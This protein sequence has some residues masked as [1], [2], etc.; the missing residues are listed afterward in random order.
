MQTDDIVKYCNLMEEVKRRMNVINAFGSGA[1]HA[2]YKATTVESV[3]LQLRK[4]LEL[5]A[6]GSLVANKQL[7]SQVY[8]DFSKLWNAKKL[9]ADIEH[10]HRIVVALSETIRL[11]TAIDCEIEKHGGWPGAFQTAKKD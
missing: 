11:M 5:I 6:F 7:F 2:L 10:Y 3:Y 9:L 1:S 8:A 4:I